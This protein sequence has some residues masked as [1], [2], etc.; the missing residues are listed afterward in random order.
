MIHINLTTFKNRLN[1]GKT[2]IINT[3]VIIYRTKITGIA[4]INFGCL[5]M[6]F[7]KVNSSNKWR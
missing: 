6:P 3:K 2:T 1:S 4:V 5:I 7:I